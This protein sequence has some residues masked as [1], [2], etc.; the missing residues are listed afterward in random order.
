MAIV[1]VPAE[2]RRISDPA[3]YSFS[4][5]SK[6]TVLPVGAASIVAVSRCRR[7]VPLYRA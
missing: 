7:S 4:P 2:A 3:E 6:V 1:T 5:S